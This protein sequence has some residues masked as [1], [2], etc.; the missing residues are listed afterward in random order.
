MQVGRY[1]W[2]Y[3][4]FQIGGYNEARNT[5]LQYDIEVTTTLCAQ[6]SQ[7]HRFAEAIWLFGS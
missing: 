7:T 6:P 5:S 4:F 3:S 1:N 2:K